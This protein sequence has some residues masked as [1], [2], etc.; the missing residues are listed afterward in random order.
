VTASGGTAP[1]LAELRD[2]LDNAGINDWCWPE[3]LEVIEAMPRNAMGKIRKV[4]LRADIVSSDR[5]HYLAEIGDDPASR[6]PELVSARL[7]RG[8]PRAK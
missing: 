5:P 6:L 2:Y 1:T 7:P 8:H 3:R 4:D